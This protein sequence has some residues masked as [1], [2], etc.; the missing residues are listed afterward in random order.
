[1]KID[2]KNT[3]KLGFDEKADNA[4]HSRSS[5]PAMFLIVICCHYIEK[6]SREHICWTAT[7]Q[8]NLS[9]AAE[10]GIYRGSLKHEFLVIS[11]VLL[12]WLLVV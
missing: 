5:H 9:K 3:G 6:I 4:M 12:V 8:D 10:F 7:M 11:G 2:L 1:M